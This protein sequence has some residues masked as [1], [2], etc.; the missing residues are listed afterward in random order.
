MDDAKIKLSTLSKS[1]KKLQD[2]VDA[3]K[4]S[5]LVN[6]RLELLVASLFWAWDLWVLKSFQ[7]AGVAG[8]SVS[9]VSLN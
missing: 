4:V 6:L 3:T 8:F 1:R 9:K 7:L 5:W 2:A